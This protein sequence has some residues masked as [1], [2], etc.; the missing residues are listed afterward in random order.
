MSVSYE[1]A[2]L[3]TCPHAARAGRA[4]SAV[5]NANGA[6]GVSHKLPIL[7]FIYFDAGGGHR[8]SAEALREA[9]AR[10]GR[11]WTVRLVNLQELLD[12]IDIVRKLTGLRL[13]DVYN[14]VVRR[15]WTL[16]SPQMLRVLSAVIQSF[17]RSSCRLIREHWAQVGEKPDLV[18]SFVPHFNRALL[19][20]LRAVLPDVPFVTIITDLADYPPHFWLEKQEQIFICGTEKAVEQGRQMGLAP[21]NLRRTSGMIIHP[22][23]YDPI[24]LDVAEERRRLGLRTD[25]LTGLVMFGGLGSDDMLV[26]ERELARSGMPIQLIHICGRNEKLQQA[27]RREPLRHPRFIEGFTSQIPY[28]MHLS[29]FFIGK[30]GPGSVSEALVK[31]LPVVVQRN[32]WTLPQER[33]NAVWIEEQRVGVVLRNF[34]KISDAVRRL[35]AP[36]VL[37][38]M[39]ENAARVGNRAV[40]EIPEILAELLT[41][42]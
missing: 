27:L 35:T 8:A 26:V 14:E 23:F 2:I 42:K 17:H 36:Q 1:A 28:Y 37:A 18:V 9:V 22:R 21:K 33:Y 19:Q 41:G 10:S 12:P 31:G 25:T 5:H 34:N 24:A 11:Q 15:G 38:E 6:S 3:A 30:P 39:K 4:F 29:D 40:F 13:Q 16:G 20:G 32:A 7:D